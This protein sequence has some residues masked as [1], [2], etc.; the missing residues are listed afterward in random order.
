MRKLLVIAAAFEALTG[1]VLIIDPSIIGSLLLGV[2][3]SVSGIA[4][5]R[6]A[7]CA[8]LG[9]G[10]AGW[11]K[12]AGHNGGA[13]R[14]LF[15]YNA[16]ATVFFL[17]LGVRG[18]LVGLLLWPAAAIHGAIAIALAGILARKAQ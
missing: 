11:P 13:A 12:P 1:L 10:I 7:G 6:L 5:G 4:V 8:L 2:E 3:L 18:E 17:Y 16:L 14:G 15:T 9:L